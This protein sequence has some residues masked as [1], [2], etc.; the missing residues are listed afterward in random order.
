M[1]LD[2]SLKLEL[3]QLSYY[4]DIFEADVTHQLPVDLGFFQ[5]D[6]DGEEYRSV[7]IP[8][9]A[10]KKKSVGLKLKHDM[11]VVTIEITYR[12]VN[13]TT[14]EKVGHSFRYINPNYTHLFSYSYEGREDCPS[15]IYY[16]FRYD[17]DLR[18]A[19]SKDPKTHLQ[20]LHN[21]PRFVLSKDSG[22]A[23][24]MRFLKTVRDCCF[25]GKDKDLVPITASLW[26][27]KR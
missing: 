27:N 13:K 6:P 26:A 3:S 22:E 23:S 12:R 24:L 19:A 21:E 7:S 16:S 15:P 5:P 9:G 14:V 17:E 4:Q 10:G 11:G 1:N 20:V 25:R 8:K 2:Q 18:P